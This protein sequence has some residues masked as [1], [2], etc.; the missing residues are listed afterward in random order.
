MLL[1]MMMVMMMMII[2]IIMISR[3]IQNTKE[4]N[5]SCRRRRRVNDV[6]RQQSGQS[7]HSHM[8]IQ[9]KW[10][11]V[12]ESGWQKH[13]HACHRIVTGES[14]LMFHQSRVS[15][16]FEMK[17]N[18][19]L[20][21]VNEWLFAS[22]HPTLPEMTGSPVATFTFARLHFSWRR[23][24]RR[25]GGKK[26]TSPWDKV[27]EWESRLITKKGNSLLWFTLLVKVG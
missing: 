11:A 24:R 1:M 18:N 23:R 17:E 13:S 21:L 2:I 6:T 16:E 26:F 27:G 12:C 9:W 7:V 4:E 14:D 3:D 5:T 10:F 22:S 20:T 8:N 15:P 25:G 19:V